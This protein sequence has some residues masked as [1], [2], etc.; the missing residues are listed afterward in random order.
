MARPA[1]PGLFGR[2]E[3]FAVEPA[4]RFR[5]GLLRFP[6]RLFL[7]G[8]EKHAQTSL[9]AQILCLHHAQFNS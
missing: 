6:V 4:V 3:L 2:L 8:F 1:K 9:V 5:R 7:F